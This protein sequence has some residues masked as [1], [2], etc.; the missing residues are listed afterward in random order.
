MRLS[1]RLAVIAAFALAAHASAATYSVTNTNDS[2]AGSLRQAILDA[3][4]NPG[5]DTITFA[6]PSSDPNCDAGGVCTISPATQLGDVSETVTID[7]YTQTG[8]SV[9]T[10]ADGTN[11]VL[12]IVLSAALIP[13]Q[14]GLNLIAG[15]SIIRGIVFAGPWGE[16][17][18]SVTTTGI[19]VAGCF[20][21]IDADGLTAN[22][23]ETDCI[24]TFVDD[25]VLI[26]GP[27]LAD[28]NLFGSSDVFIATEASTHMTVRNNLF[29]TDRTGAV[30]LPSFIAI[31]TDR[32]TT[33]FSALDNVIDG[34]TNEGMNLG[35]SS[36]VKGNFIGVDATG[37]IPLPG[38]IEG[39]QLFND[40]AIGGASPG[41][42]N[43]IRGCTTGIVIPGGGHGDTIRGN[44]IYDNTALGI[45]VG[46]AG[47]T[48]NDFPE[49]DGFQNFPVLKSVT[50]G[51]TTH[52]VAELHSTASTT[53]DIDFFANSACSNFPREFVQGEIFLG[54]SP[55]TTDGTG[56][57][58]IDIVLPVAT[59]TGARI[60]M[61]ATS[62]VAGANTSEFSQRLPFSVLAASGPPAGGTPIQVKGTDF[63]TGATVKIGGVAA[64]GI[65]VSDFDTIDATTPALA[66]GSVN[67][68]VV[69]NTDGTTG[70]LVKGWVA[71]FLDVPGTQIFYTYVTKLVSNGITVGVGG[72]LYGVNQ[73]TL[74]QQMAVF[75]MKAK[76]GL[77]YAPPPCTIP[78]F[79]DVPCSS[80]FAPW[81][82][83]LVTE[84]VTGGCGDGTTY[85]PTDSVKRQQMAVLLLRTAL[86]SS[87][88]PPACVTATFD[89]V[90]CSS[91]FAPWIYDLVSRGITGGCGNND[92][93]P[94]DPA[95]RGQM[96]VFV[97]KTFHLQ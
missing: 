24:S 3:N 6:I 71:D 35:A 77:C 69:T 67:D 37:T 78:A 81:I 21:G 57:A 14:N 5:T 27:S 70:T 63:E 22:A 11:A 29:G 17:V 84:G 59:E 7:G 1:P 34:C 23:C 65:T 18:G 89:D 12:K 26:G 25:S 15:T 53:F 19:Q 20:F 10:L 90:P 74:R 62:Q 97:V 40:A 76:H 55:V 43:V 4:A 2:G 83:E 58:Q 30:A 31:F 86:G 41:E 9:N 79:T 75:L 45:D 72:G 96:A 87:Y 66:P 52:V 46:P 60:A 93:C 36:T 95:T 61:T 92:Y 28:R 47:A 73:P 16:A 38:P 68:L 48:A 13:N 39:I 94:G 82:N 51:A 54:T 49:A 50:T 64:T 42:G 91:S 80:N 56:V 32:D 88:A 44:S 33:N 85:C 8:A